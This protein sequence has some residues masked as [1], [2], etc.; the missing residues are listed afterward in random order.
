M[1]RTTFP[2]LGL[3]HSLECVGTC[4]VYLKM[5]DFPRGPVIKNLPAN[6]GDMG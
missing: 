6:A 2:L 4:N 1:E 3:H 5:L